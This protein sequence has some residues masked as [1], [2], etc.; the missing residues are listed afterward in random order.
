MS[1]VGRLFVLAAAVV[2]TA[3]AAAVGAVAAHADTQQCTTDPYTGVVTCIVVRDP[4]PPPGSSAPSSG[5]G[6]TGCTWAGAAVPCSTDL[7]WFS[8][9]C[10]WQAM[11]PQ[12]AAGDPAWQGHSPGEGMIYRKYCMYDPPGPYYIWSADP[13]PGA[14]ATLPPA[15]TVALRAEAQLALPTL[16]AQSNASAA[17]ATYVAVPTWLWVDPAG[18]HPLSASASVGTRAVTVT[19]TPVATLWNTGDGSAPVRCAGPGAAFD[20]ARPY[21]PPCGHTYRTSSARQPQTG[22]APNDRYFTVRGSVVFAIH[23]VCSGDCDQASGDLADMT[24]GT[25]AMPLRVFEVQTVVVNH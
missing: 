24:W 11:S 1:R 15:A 16:R 13:P 9:G 18:W 19:A 23:W 4:T 17:A 14:P 25:T 3:A 5:G 10:Y 6:P 8:N 22:P 20:P 7:G 21:D 2:A 12:P